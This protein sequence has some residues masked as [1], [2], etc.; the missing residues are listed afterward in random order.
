MQLW[1]SGHGLLV[2]SL[3]QIPPGN[4]S[5]T[6]VLVLQSLLAL[7]ADPAGAGEPL[8]PAKNKMNRLLTASV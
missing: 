1:P 6:Q 5:V 4:P 3:V 8:Q 2:Q 7:Q